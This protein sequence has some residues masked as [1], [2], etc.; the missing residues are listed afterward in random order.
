MEGKLTLLPLAGGGW[1]GVK[2]PYAEGGKVMGITQ[3]R[4]NDVGQNE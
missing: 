3:K 1:E 2:I 4:N